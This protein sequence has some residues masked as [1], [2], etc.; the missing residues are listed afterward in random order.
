VHEVT[1]DLPTRE[2]GKADVHFLVKQD[3]SILG[4]LEVSKGAIVWYPK[5]K[6]IGH[7]IGWAKLDDLA[8]DYPRIEHRKP[9]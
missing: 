4:K 5:N 3:G 1:F 6:K 2:L 9:R 8:R 7:K